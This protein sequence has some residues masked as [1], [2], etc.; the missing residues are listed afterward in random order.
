MELMYELRT[1]EMER[2]ADS[3]F[4]LVQIFAAAQPRT[5]ETKEQSFGR[6][7]SKIYQFCGDIKNIHRV[8]KVEDYTT[9][10]RGKLSG[11]L[12]W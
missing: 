8:G 5:Y 6:D 3:S 10:R 4:P 1:V 7:L 11:L 9:Q 12:S 2:P